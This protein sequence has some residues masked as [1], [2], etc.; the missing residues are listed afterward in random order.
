MNVHPES[1]FSGDTSREALRVQYAALRRMTIPERIAAMDDLTRTVR[2]L[3][4]E[5]LRRRHP[6]LDAAGIEE[7]YFELVLGKDLAREVLAHRRARSAAP[8]P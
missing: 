4:Y 2:E 6:T 7:L 8:K 5:G 3:A 1:A